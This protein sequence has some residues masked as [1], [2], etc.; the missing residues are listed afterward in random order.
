MR[1]GKVVS[2]L[3]WVALIPLNYMGVILGRI[4]DPIVVLFVNKTTYFLPNWLSWFQTPDNPLTGDKGWK[5]RFPEGKTNTYFAMVRWLWRNNMNGFDRTVLGAPIADQQLIV[6]E[7]YGDPKTTNLPRVHAG[8]YLK[9][10]NY[11]G[12]WYFHFYLI[13]PITSK[14]ALRITLGWKLFEPFPPKSNVKHLQYTCTIWPNASI[15]PK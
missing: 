13:K 8:K 1:F 12:K 4:L 5:E 2:V 14:K 10:V 3:K 6:T 9:W 7:V 15:G 11:G